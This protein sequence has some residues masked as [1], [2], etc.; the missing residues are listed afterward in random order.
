MDDAVK[1]Y[2]DFMAAYSASAR[3][4]KA[5][6]REFTP[7]PGTFTGKRMRQKRCY[8]NAARMA[9]NDSRYTYVEGIVTVFGIPIDHAWVLDADGEI[10]D[11]TIRPKADEDPAIYFGVPVPTAD[12]FKVLGKTKVW[13]GVLAHID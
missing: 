7:G 1:A 8:E 13:G 9:M 12:L 10:V 6:G 3:V 11:P 4:L 5:R 2:V